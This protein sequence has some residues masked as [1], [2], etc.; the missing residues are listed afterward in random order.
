MSKFLFLDILDNYIGDNL[1]GNK[2]QGPR[3]IESNLHHA[4]Q[5]QSWK[6]DLK[7]E[8][9]EFL[10]NGVWARV[11]VFNTVNN[12][13]LFIFKTLLACDT[14]LYLLGSKL[15]LIRNQGN[16]RSVAWAVKKERKSG[17]RN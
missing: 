5:Q 15:W 11:Y 1:H 2:K 12:C 17:L 14:W 7:M 4:L 3:R 9:M 13:C 10:K 6:L 8:E 16:G